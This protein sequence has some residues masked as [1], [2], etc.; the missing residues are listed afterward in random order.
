[1]ANYHGIKATITVYRN[2]HFNSRGEAI[3]AR[4]LDNNGI[5]WK[6]EPPKFSIIGTTKPDFYVEIPCGN[7]TYKYLI[8]YKP[9]ATY[10]SYQDNF[11]KK[12]AQFVINGSIDGAI[13][14][15]RCWYEDN[16]FKIIGKVHQEIKWLFD[17]DSKKVQDN[18][19][20]AFNYRYE[21]VRED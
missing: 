9:A 14:V 7:R 19:N 18:I 20:E 1:M 2:I 12:T 13:I 8:E 11:R 4:Y 16:K 6:Y 15:Q 5:N 21:F 17:S 10:K 3:F